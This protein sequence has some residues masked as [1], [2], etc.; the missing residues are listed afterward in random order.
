M[1]LDLHQCF[2]RVN[3]LALLFALLSA[4]HALAQTCKFTNVDP[5]PSAVPCTSPSLRSVYGDARCAVVPLNQSITW[6]PENTQLVVQCYRDGFL[7]NQFGTQAGVAS[8]SISIAQCTSNTAAEHEIKL[9][10]P[11]AGAPC[12]SVPVR[13]ID[14]QTA[15][16]TVP[17]SVSFDTALTWSPA[18]CRLTI[19]GYES[20]RLVG[21]YNDTGSSDVRI[22]QL[23]TRT[24][25][26][27]EIKGW[28]AG[29]GQPAD[30]KFVE[31]HDCRTTRF[32]IA[33]IVDFD[34]PIRW[35]LDD[36]VGSVQ[37]YQGSRLVGERADAMSGTVRIG[38]L[39]SNV[40]W[41]E[42]KYWPRG[43]TQPSTTRYVM[44]V[45]RQTEPSIFSFKDDFEIDRGWLQGT[46][47]EIVNQYY[48][49]GIGTVVRSGDAWF[50]PASS[51][52]LSPND[53]GTSQSNHLSAGNRLLDAGQRGQ[54]RLRT[55]VF[56]PSSSASSGQTGP[57][58]SAQNSRL[59]G[60]ETATFI[61][62]LQYNSNPSEQGSWVVWTSDGVASDGPP[63]WVF[64]GKKE[65]RRDWWYTVNLDMDFDSNKYIGLAVLGDDVPWE[66]LLS[67]PIRPELRGF[68]P[69]FVLTLE[70][71][72][73]FT[74]SSPQVRKNVVYYDD[75]ELLRIPGPP[76]NLVA[77]PNGPSLSLSWSPP[78][79]DGSTTGYFVEVG[80]RSG[81][82]D[83]AV[84]ANRT[85]SFFADRVSP[86]TYYVRVR[87]AN[88]DAKGPPSNEVVVTIDA[89][90]LRQLDPPSPLTYGVTGSTVTLN[91]S[92]LPEAESYVIQA[93]SAPGLSD[94][95]DRDTM[96]PAL[97][98]VATNVQN[99]TYYV[100][101][102]GKNRCGTSGPS[103]EVAFTIG[104][105][106]R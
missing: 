1:R 60:T 104:G 58:F 41:T 19:Q 100:R 4:R 88:D 44:V 8:R 28:V 102:R 50:S 99:G 101:L 96:N 76:T 24:G 20:G 64:I 65:L 36:C 35:V 2:R 31:I 72:N 84:F 23:A 17:S 18:E 54:F 46:T 9:W 49:T 83:R 75:I 14:C 77:T 57:E 30:S 33:T 42:L 48:G 25:R 52:K 103:N 16:F 69:A 3:V 37:A 12:H 93:G 86:G 59:Q 55:K 91:W 78:I 27:L 6:Q 79:P 94:L 87:A 15:R 40:G 32:T 47:E 43:A 61:A 63:K 89:T 39:V 71:E 26:S 92:R 74:G 5:G 7:V 95:A 51:L 13:A 22:G 10:L 98:F 68:E 97:S 66:V 80:S 82:K 81:A 45:E 21:Q 70:A 38:N 11:R 29:A 53:V 62:G 106:D 90:C 67:H 73:L 105:P 56:L 85:A 34:K